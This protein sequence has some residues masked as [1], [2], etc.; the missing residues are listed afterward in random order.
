MSSCKCVM[1]LTVLA[2]AGLA[3]AED[4]LFSS[5]IGDHPDGNQNPPPYGLR[6]DNLFDAIGGD[7]G[8]TTFSF[9]Q[10]GASSIIEIIDSNSDLIADKIRIS[11][12]VYG[13]E[14]D[15]DNYDWGEGLYELFFEISA[16]VTTEGGPFDGWHTSGNSAGAGT[17]TALGN[18]DTVTDGQ[19]FNFYKQKT[20][21]NGRG[22]EYLRDRHRLTDQ[23]GEEGPM[24]DLASSFRDPTLFNSIVG[25]GWNTF[26][27]DG[28]INSGGTQDWL[29]ITI[30]LPSGGAMA[31]AG[32]G[33]L[34]FRRRR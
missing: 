26:D 30:P 24:A 19:V 33:F 31:I 18:Y 5:R 27:P 10:N 7:D 23:A 1:A 11:G 21:V 12:T 34:A 6:L 25:R 17:L 9:E 15:G 32:F 2:G 22:F 29:F 16:A 3:M 4:V 13:G 28:V 20:G 14:T 8:V